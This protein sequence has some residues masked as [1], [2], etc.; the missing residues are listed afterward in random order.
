MARPTVL[1]V[2][3]ED[4]RR[5][6][7]VRGL[8]SYGY[9]VVGASGADEGRRFAE[10]LRPGLLV[11]EAPLVDAAD[12]FGLRATLPSSDAGVPTTMLFAAEEADDLPPGVLA[13]KDADVSATTLLLKV[14]TVLVGGDLGLAVDARLDSLVGNLQTSPLFELLPAL[15]RAVVTGRVEVAEGQLFLEEGEVVAARLAGHSGVKAFARLARTADG[16]FRVVLGPP[17]AEREIFKDLLTMFSGRPSSRP[18]SPP[19]NSA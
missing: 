2:D 13:V 10:G 3:R 11:V 16:T 7:L 5:K 19:V 14:R 18:S 15:Q 12:P 8:T 1:V 9:E 4:R 17:T 6:E